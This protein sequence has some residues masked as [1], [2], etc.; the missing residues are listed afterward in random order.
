M[1]RGGLIDR[2]NRRDFVEEDEAKKRKKRM[3]GVEGA[4]HVHR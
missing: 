3:K 1:K 2:E 4:A